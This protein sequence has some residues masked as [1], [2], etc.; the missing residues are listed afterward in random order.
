MPVAKR[1]GVFGVLF[2]ALLECSAVPLAAQTFPARPG[3]REFVLDQASLIAPQ[4]KEQIRSLCGKL[5]QETRT[6]IIVVTIPSLAKYRANDIDV[7][8]RALFDNW[9]IG[10]QSDNSGILL[11]VSLGDR[12]AR[13]ELGAAWAHLQDTTA[14]MIMQEIIVPNFKQGNYSAGILQGVQGLETMARGKHVTKPVPWWQPALFWGLIILGITAAVS[15]IRSGRAGWG[16]ALLAAIGLI[17]AGIVAMMLS[18]RGGGSSFGGGS[19]G[20]GGATGS[21]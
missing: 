6:P 8:A 13:I 1:L 12:K 3:Q 16:W 9:G 14:Q 11:L 5:L 21:W 17:L 15:L 18:G 20:G 2:V 7:Y 19:G 10:S 4:E